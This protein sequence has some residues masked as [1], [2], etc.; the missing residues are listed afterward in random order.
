MTKDEALRAMVDEGRIGECPCGEWF[1][2]V[3]KGFAQIYCSM[4]CRNKYYARSKHLGVANG[5]QVQA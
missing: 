4:T 2:A 1:I 5:N 3:R